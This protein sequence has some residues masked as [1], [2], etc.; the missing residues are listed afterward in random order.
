MWM[1]QRIK[2]FV[3]TTQYY[4]TEIVNSDSYINL[5]YAEHHLLRVHE[6]VT[7]F[8]SSN[9]AAL[10]GSA[11]IMIISFVVLAVAAAVYL[12]GQGIAHKDIPISPSDGQQNLIVIIAVAL[13]GIAG[14]MALFEG[15]WTYQTWIYYGIG[16]IML[17]GYIYIMST[18][19]TKYYLA[20]AAVF[21]VI[22]AALAGVLGEGVFSNS[23]HYFI[24]INIVEAVE[25]F[26][27]IW[28]LYVLGQ[29][30]VHDCDMS[31]KTQTVIFFIVAILLVIFRLYTT[32]FRMLY[33]IGY[34]I[35][36]IGLL[37]IMFDHQR[38]S[39]FT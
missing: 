15:S 37:F 7:H 12:R 2:M 11:V 38:R 21:I 36:T 16:N 19:A 18:K 14:I 29:V 8:A 9:G 17:A 1:L 23:N 27:L 13:L 39:I 31:R 5:M 33:M 32:H 20:L 10:S 6:A 35:A 22:F 24:L 25:G 4:F 30:M 28:A 34:L 26:S 3:Y